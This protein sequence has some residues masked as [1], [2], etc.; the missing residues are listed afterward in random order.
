MTSVKFN[1]YDVR[2]GSCAGRENNFGEAEIYR[3]VLFAG[4]STSLFRR[5]SSLDFFFISSS[6]L[7]GESLETLSGGVSFLTSRF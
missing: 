7:R 2:L 4:R 3:S 6:S 1:K 5:V